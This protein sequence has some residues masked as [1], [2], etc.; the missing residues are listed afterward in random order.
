VGS[1]KPKGFNQTQ[2]EFARK[3]GGSQKYISKILNNSKLKRI[4]EAENNPIEI[5]IG[6]DFPIY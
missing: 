4:R 5:L 6:I 3:L 2:N 1:Y